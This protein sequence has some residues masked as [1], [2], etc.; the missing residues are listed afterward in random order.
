[1]TRHV[2][3]VAGVFWA[4]CFQCAAEGLES[5]SGNVTVVVDSEKPLPSEAVLTL[6]K[7]IDRLF[8]ATKLRID[9]VNRSE[10]GLGFEAADLVLVRLRGDCSAAAMPPLPPDE[11][12]PLARTHISHGTVISYSEVECGRVARAAQSALHGGERAR[13]QEMMG[14][15]LG[16]VVAHELLHIFLQQKSHAP[17]GIFRRGLTPRQLVETFGGDEDEGRI[18]VDAQGKPA[19]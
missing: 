3:A 8:S 11:L 2:A 14:R 10:A 9:W 15:A 19:S 1:M 13:P 18:L 5:L 12:G 6:K 7:E 4:L 17:K 16:R